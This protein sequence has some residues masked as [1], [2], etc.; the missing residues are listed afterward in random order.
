MTELLSVSTVLPKHC[1]TALDA[2]RDLEARFPAAMAERFRRF[3]RASGN[4]TRHLVLPLHR[5]R[6]LDSVEERSKLYEEHAVALA[7]QAARQA[8]EES[9][10]SSESVSAIVA[11][12]STGHLMPTLE[13]R[14]IGRLGLSPRCRR[15]PLTQLGCAGGTAAIALGSLLIEATPGRIV[16]IVSV[17]LPSLS[18]PNAEPSTSDVV[19]SL[20]FGDGAGAAVL[21]SGREDQGPVVLGTA[22]FLFPETIENDGTWLTTTGLRLKRPRG[23]VAVLRRD[24]ARTVD[25]FLAAHGLARRDVDFWVLQPRNADLLDAA[26]ASLGLSPEAAGPSREVWRT[27]GNLVSAAVFH[28]LAE[29]RGAAPPR[30][31]RHGLIV[32][33]GAGFACEMVLL[34]AAGWLSAAQAAGSRR[35][36]SAAALPAV[37]FS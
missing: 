23:L 30:L 19:A 28:V 33:F 6:Q 34:R 37:E 18:F 4:D 31:G 5:L 20:Q 13:S 1:V 3:L 10:V 29:I 24:L 16:L 8:L 27:R 14:L 35:R 25:D 22:S 9:G 21:R 36:T 11:V 26:A 2:E 32:T 17:E 7:E 12:S 15:I